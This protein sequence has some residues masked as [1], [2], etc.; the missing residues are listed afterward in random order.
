MTVLMITTT[1]KL[2][3]IMLDPTSIKNIASTKKIKLK[4]VAQ[5]RKTSR[6]LPGSKSPET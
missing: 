4:N 2:S 5:W 3:L 1:R 6:R